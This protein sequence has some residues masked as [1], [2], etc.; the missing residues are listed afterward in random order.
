MTAAPRLGR[1]SRSGRQQ[2]LTLIELVIT[3][4][5]MAIRASRAVPEGGRLL[6]RWKLQAT[7]ERL[8]ADLQAAR[9]DAIERGLTQHVQLLSGTRWCWSVSESPGCGCEEPLSCQRIRAVAP[10]GG[11]VLLESGTRLRF[12]PTA[13]SRTSPLELPISNAFGDRL[14]IALTPMGRSRICTPGRPAMGY[15]AC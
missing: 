4:A 1:G 10:Q 13:E 12:E 5:L 14:Q 8:S 6:A 15:P 3:L 2:G 9:L 7:A 11:G